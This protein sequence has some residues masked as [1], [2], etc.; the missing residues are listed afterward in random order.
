MT[1]SPIALALLLAVLAL[2][3]AGCRQGEAAVSAGER[4][5]ELAV[6]SLLAAW[7]SGNRELIADLFLPQA[8]YDDF[9]NQVTYLGVEEIIGYVSAVHSWGD[10]VYM[11]VGRM[12]VSESGAVAEWVFSAVQNR[13]IGRHVS[14]ATGREVVLNGVTIIEMQDGRILRAADYTDTAPM[15]LQLGGRIEL[16]GGTVLELDGLGN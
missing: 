16:P 14:V 9:P 7:E 3:V 4:E 6:R 8:T 15:T 12:H 13:P 10:D 2:T 1:R 5:A 11:S